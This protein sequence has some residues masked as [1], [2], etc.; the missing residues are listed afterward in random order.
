LG[1]SLPLDSF[2]VSLGEPAILRATRPD[3]E[4]AGCWT[5]LSLGV[6]LAY[7]AAV[8]IECSVLSRR[9]E[10]VETLSKDL[11]LPAPAIPRASLEFRFWDWNPIS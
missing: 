6:D 2:D 10:L 4:E 1:L 7:T 9:V 3:P 11:S 8:A 5:L